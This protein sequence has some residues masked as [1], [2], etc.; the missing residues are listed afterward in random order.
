M[1]EVRRTLHPR[2]NTTSCRWPASGSVGTA[3][4][5]GV[6]S[7]VLTT[8]AWSRAARGFHRQGDLILVEPD[9]QDPHGDA[10]ARTHDFT[11]VLHEPIGQLGDVHEPVLMDADVD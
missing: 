4:V 8:R 3:L 7:H 9:L 11:R 6:A 5:G 2:Y 1:C 10:V